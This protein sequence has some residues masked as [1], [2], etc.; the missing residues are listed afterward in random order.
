MKF[1]SSLHGEQDLNLI[2]NLSWKHVLMSGMSGTQNKTPGLSSAFELW[3]TRNWAMGNHWRLGRW[4]EIRLQNNGVCEWI[5]PNAL[6]SGSSILHEVNIF[7]GEWGCQ[8]D[9]N[10][11]ATHINPAPICVWQNHTTFSPYPYRMVDKMAGFIFICQV[12]MDLSIFPR[13]WDIWQDSYAPWSGL[14]TEAPL[15]LLFK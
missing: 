12:C 4:G 6:H 11:A 15:S 13:I 10:S 8:I 3:L 2:R 9:Y 1:W 5:K 7:Q 14:T